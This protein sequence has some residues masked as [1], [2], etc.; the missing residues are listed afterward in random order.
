MLY[1]KNIPKFMAKLIL[2]PV[3]LIVFFTKFN[4]EVQTF[5]TVNLTE[6]FKS[7][8]LRAYQI[9]IALLLACC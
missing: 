2:S 6:N 1:Q 5:V 4:F 8:M 3:I 7:V 9:K